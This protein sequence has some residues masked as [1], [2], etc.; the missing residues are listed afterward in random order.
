VKSGK[1][2]YL[3][4]NYANGDMVGHTGNFEAAV[5]AM[6]CLDLQLARL[7]PAILAAN[8]TLMIT[9]DHGNA[10]E[11]YELDKKGNVKAMPQGHLGQDLAHAESGALRA[12]VERGRPGFGLRQD[13]AA[14]ACQRRRDGAQP[15]R[16][17]A[18]YDPSLIEPA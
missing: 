4:V 1:Y 7:V 14:R 18:D 13:L 17:P 9:A 12:G 8:G 11:M 15:A 16:L 3:R 2:R 10:D 5:T 6:Q